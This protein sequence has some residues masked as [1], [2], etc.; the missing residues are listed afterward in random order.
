MSS[1]N[2]PHWPE[3]IE[4]F[5][6]GSERTLLSATEANRI[7][8]IYNRFRNM[9]AGTGIVIIWAEAGPIISLKNAVN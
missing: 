1:P 3:F 8:D 4:P 9:K 6:E 7:I 5:E 2:N